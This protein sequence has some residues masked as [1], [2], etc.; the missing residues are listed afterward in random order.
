MRTR[1]DLPLPPL[2]QQSVII[3][4]A[5]W[6][7]RGPGHRGGGG[8]GGKWMTNLCFSRNQEFWRGLIHPHLPPLDG[9]LLPIDCTPLSWGVYEWSGCYAPPSCWGWLDAF[10][11]AALFSS[12][13]CLLPLLPFTI[14]SSSSFSS[15]PAPQPLWES[16]QRRR[17]GHLSSRPLNSAAPLT[18]K[19]WINPCYCQQICGKRRMSIA[20]QSNTDINILFMYALINASLYCSFPGCFQFS[21]IKL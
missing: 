16:T 2:K 3:S 7:E 10:I 1:L 11:N 8:G 12:L 6:V 14:A 15:L 20:Q 19:Q 5:C 9:P 18:G 13:P 21:L 4:L 17:L